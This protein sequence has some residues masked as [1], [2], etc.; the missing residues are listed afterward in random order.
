MLAWMVSVISACA[1]PGPFGIQ[2]SGDKRR[3][4]QSQLYIQSTFCVEHHEPYNWV[5][6]RPIMPRH[7]FS[8]VA[9]ILLKGALAQ[10]VTDVSSPCVSDFPSGATHLSSSVHCFDA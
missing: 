8:L 10:N 5:Q 4:R 3:E 6:H 2:T 9:A 7:S 1:H